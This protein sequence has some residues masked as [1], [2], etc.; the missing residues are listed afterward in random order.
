MDAYT[1]APSFSLTPSFRRTPEPCVFTRRILSFATVLLA[2]L[3][4]PAHAQWKVVDN[5]AN[6]TLKDI[7]QD[8]SNT[9]HKDLSTTLHQDLQKIHTLGG[10]KQLGDRAVDPDQ[11]L[12]EQMLQKDIEQC[13]NI[14]KGQQPI[15]EE[16]VKTRNAQMNYMVTMY[17]LAAQTRN[18]QLKQIQDERSRL[19]SSDYGKLEDN[20]N[21]LIAL[22]TQLQIDQQ[23]TQTV[24]YAYETRLKY[25]RELQTNSTHGMLTGSDPSPSS[26][27][28]MIKQIGAGLV[29]GVALKSALEAEKTSKPSGMKTLSSTNGWSP[30]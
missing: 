27:L 11:Q 10:Y 23:Q 24:M 13:N 12:T 1:M 18:D 9:I 14:T 3:A 21:K 7:H 5:D 8:L 25:L 26:P 20:T 30:L 2:A 16:I 17:K 22:Q 19:Q 4:T 28:D 6:R 29:T 15:C